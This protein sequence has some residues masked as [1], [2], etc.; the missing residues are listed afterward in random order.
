MDIGNS[1][2]QSI[3]LG[4]IKNQMLTFAISVVIVGL[5]GVTMKWDVNPKSHSM[6]M[7][8]TVD[9]RQAT[10]ETDSNEI[11][12]ANA[13]VNDDRDDNIKCISRCV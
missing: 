13:N 10:G 4:W 11:E 12:N 9:S 1:F 6:M 7:T 2:T 3:P 8:T 5:T